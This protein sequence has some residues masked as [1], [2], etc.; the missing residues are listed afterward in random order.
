M[1]MIDKPVSLGDGDQTLHGS[2]VVPEGKQRRDAVLIWSGSGPTDRDGNSG[3]ALKNNG[4]KMLSHGLGEAGYVSLRTDKR[5]IGESASAVSREA[6]LRFETYVEDAVRWAR[7]L[8]DAP[9]VR[10]VF[11]LGHSEGGLVATLA[12]QQFR[13][14]GLVLLAA[15]GFPAAQLIRRQLAAP[16]IIIPEAQLTEIHAIMRSLEA[17]ELV[18][19]IPAELEI[20]YRVSV[21]PYLISW[22]KYDPAAELAK[23]SGPVLVVQGTNDLQVSVDDADRLATAREDITPLKIK[24]MN[25]VLKVAP[26]DRSGNFATY[27]KPRLPLAPGLVTA[28]TDF[29]TANS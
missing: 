23:V 15:V 5:G 7:F 16:G 18:P 14:A 3:Q 4:L 24:G 29:L 17:G 9:N 22:F 10:N 11:L 20:Q 21:Q 2:L 12:A 13:A 25:H 1:L 8:K 27:I 26:N 28:V 6:D 19:T